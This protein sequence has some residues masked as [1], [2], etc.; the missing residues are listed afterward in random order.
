MEPLHNSTR[1]PTSR[2]GR[3]PANNDTTMSTA[4]SSYETAPAMNNNGEVCLCFQGP[5]VMM[6]QKASPNNQD[7]CCTCNMDHMGNDMDISG[8]ARMDYDDQTLDTNKSKL[9]RSQRAKQSQKNTLREVE[10]TMANMNDDFD[11]TIL[12][13]EDD[14]SNVEPLGRH[15]RINSFR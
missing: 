7:C 15:Y 1:K 12:E 13:V 14:P 2:R 10:E 8:I 9:S 4:R 11:E 5:P 6:Q 3:N